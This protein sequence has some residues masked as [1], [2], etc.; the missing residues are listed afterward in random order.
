MYLKASDLY[1]S[2]MSTPDDSRNMVKLILKKFQLV[3]HFVDSD[4]NLNEWLK[5]NSHVANKYQN[6]NVPI[7]ENI[8]RKYELL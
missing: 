8:N 7:N 3:K 6:N 2:L 1:Q 5:M 4:K